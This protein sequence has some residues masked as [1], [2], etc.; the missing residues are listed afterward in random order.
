MYGKFVLRIYSYPLKARSLLLL[1]FVTKISKSTLCLGGPKVEKSPPKFLY[2]LFF[3]T[4]SAHSFR[5]PKQ[6]IIGDFSVSP[7]CFKG[8]ILPYFCLN[9]SL[10]KTSP[11]VS[12]FTKLSQS[13][14]TLRCSYSLQSH[15]PTV[16]CRCYVLFFGF[17]GGG[18][19]ML[20]K[21][22]V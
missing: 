17:F 1:S 5:G 6:V 18:L 9:D 19:L 16:V 4:V 12:T 21:L 2:S 22:S 11:L 7:L 14:A 3:S 10:Y 15:Y 13:S 20:T 8:S